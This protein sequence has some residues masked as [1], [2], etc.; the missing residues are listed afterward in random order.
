MSKIQ[1]N[2]ASGGGSVAFEGPASLGSDKVIK[3]PTAPSVII[4]QVT[5]STTTR[6]ERGSN[7]NTFTNTALAATITPTSA[8]SKVYIQVYGQVRCDDSAT[9]GSL[10]IARGST[11]LGH[12]SRGL[13]TFLVAANGLFL[14]PV[15]MGFLDSPS[16]TSATTYTVQIA[17][18]N[19][20]NSV[21]F[22]QST[23]DPGIIILSEVA[24]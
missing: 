1:L 14:S 19:G 18:I 2:A 22:P 16:T 13:T 24:T 7:T 12:S 5:A 6:T 20:P 3:F 15:S 4:Q 23:E 17:R 10:T 21:F 11:N 9:G 8:N